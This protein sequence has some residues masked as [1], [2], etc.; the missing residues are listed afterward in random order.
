MASSTT[1]PR[2]VHRN[3]YPRTQPRRRQR[4]IRRQIIGRSSCPTRRTNARKLPSCAPKKPPS[5]AQRPPPA[6]QRLPLTRR[7]T[8]RR[9]RMRARFLRSHRSSSWP[10]AE[11]AL[12]AREGRLDPRNQHPRNQHPTSQRN[13]F[14]S[15]GACCQRRKTQSSTSQ[16]VVLRCAP[17]LPTGA[18]KFRLIAFA[19]GIA[20]TKISDQPPILGDFKNGVDA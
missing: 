5:T 7:N 11:V 16:D 2:P 19:F 15:E 20:E 8:W 12:I 17:A 18:R 13:Q 4:R 14:A 1:A 3:P 10:V 9:V 6:T